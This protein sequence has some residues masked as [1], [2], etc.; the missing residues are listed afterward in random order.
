MASTSVEGLSSQNIS[1]ALTSNP[2]PITKSIICPTYPYVI[3]CGLMIKH[4][5]WLKQA[6][7]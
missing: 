1:I 3:I 4:E 6:G 2:D 7:D 5:H